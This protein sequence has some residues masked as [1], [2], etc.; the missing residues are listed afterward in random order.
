M[1]YSLVGDEESQDETIVD[2]SFG[3][4]KALYR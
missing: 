2:T 3:R 1:P 4:I